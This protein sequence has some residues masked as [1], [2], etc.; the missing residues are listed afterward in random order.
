MSQ[1]LAEK[2]RVSYDKLHSQGTTDPD[3]MATLS[4]TGTPRRKGGN[5]ST[6]GGKK[7]KKKKAVAAMEEGGAAG[8]RETPVTPEHTP[9]NTHRGRPRRKATSPDP[10]EDWE[11]MNLDELEAIRVQEE[12][13]WDR[14]AL[15]DLHDK[16]WESGATNVAG[17][18]IPLESNWNFDFLRSIAVSQFDM[19]TVDYLQFGAPANID[20]EAHE[21]CVPPAHVPNRPGAVQHEETVKQFIQKQTARGAIIGPFKDNPFNR[22]HRVSPLNTVPKDDGK[23]RRF[24]MDLSFP[25]GSSVND[26]VS[27]DSLLHNGSW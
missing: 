24:I 19:K 18:R 1:R 27:A 12:A 15:V 17:C 25:E 8:G 14:T 11:N 10:L 5:V 3:T 4:G 20:H 6:P 26:F 21:F 7:E 9:E 13:E 16:L 22:P 23:A 2:V